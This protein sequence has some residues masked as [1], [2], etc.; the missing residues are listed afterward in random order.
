DSPFLAPVPHRGKRCEPAYVLEVAKIVADV[1]GMSLT[2]VD[3][4]TTKNAVEFF[5][6]PS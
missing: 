3:R 1:K 2:E 6:L 5:G 4:E